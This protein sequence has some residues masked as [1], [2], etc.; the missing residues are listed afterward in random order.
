MAIFFFFEKY[1]CLS[2][3][4]R[5]QLMQLGALELVMQYYVGL[6]D[7]SKFSGNEF[8]YVVVVLLLL[9]FFVTHMWVGESIM[10]F[11]FFDIQISFHY[12]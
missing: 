8:G 3:Q 12:F 6:A 2:V 11:S 10:N 1:A 9:L 7:M 5:V 4:N